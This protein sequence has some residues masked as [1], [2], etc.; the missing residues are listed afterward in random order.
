M[1]KKYLATVRPDREYQRNMK[2]K[3]SVPFNTKAS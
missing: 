3:S 2:P 1:N